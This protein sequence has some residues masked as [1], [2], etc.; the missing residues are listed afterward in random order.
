[1]NEN[2]WLFIVCIISIILIFFIIIRK[3]NEKFT[4]N[5]KF[6]N[7][8]MDTLFF[9]GSSLKDS[10]YNQLI[11]NNPVDYFS[12]YFPLVNLNSIYTLIKDKLNSFPVDKIGPIIPQTNKNVFNN[13][14]TGRDFFINAFAYK[15]NS[16]ILSNTNFANDMMRKIIKPICLIYLSNKTNVNN[17][18]KLYTL[19]IYLSW[20]SSYTKA[21]N[22]LPD[23]KKIFS[24][25]FKI[26]NDYMD[27]N[28]PMYIYYDFIANQNKGSFDESPSNTINMSSVD[29]TT[30]SNYHE[31][32]NLFNLPSPYCISQSGTTHMC[33]I[34]SDNLMYDNLLD[35]ARSSI[36]SPSIVNSDGTTIPSV[37]TDPYYQ[38]LWGNISNLTD[39]TTIINNR[40]NFINNNPLVLNIKNAGDTLS[41]FISDYVNLYIVKELFNTVLPGENII[42][43]TTFSN[44]LQNYTYINT[45]DKITSQL[46]QVLN[47]LKT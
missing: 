24:W 3:S 22:T 14:T 8:N 44:M 26:T 1:M 31:Y 34:N 45:N 23:N 7:N 46:Y 15:I 17:N 47:N 21:F 25:D 40:D 30:D 28:K 32:I 33:G 10:Y 13:T 43:P 39:K 27:I 9:P 2:F 11:Y 4:N 36:L 38:T 6:A 37:N 20:I 41:T 18:N 16:S 42:P 35:M 19:G 5:E 12:T 29:L